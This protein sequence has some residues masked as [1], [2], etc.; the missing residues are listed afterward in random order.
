VSKKTPTTTELPHPMQPIG[1]HADGVVR[2]KRNAIVDHLLDECTARGGTDLNQ[3]A[4]MVASGEFSNEDQVQLAQLIGYSVSG[5]GDLSYVPD[6]IVKRADRK[7]AKI[8]TP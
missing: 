1:W 3:I 6:K 2:F 8:V 5:F 7:A 4:R